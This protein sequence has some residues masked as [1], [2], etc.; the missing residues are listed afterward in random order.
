ML[1]KFKPSFSHINYKSWAKSETGTQQQNRQRTCSSKIAI[2][3]TTFNVQ[4]ILIS[5]FFFSFRWQIYGVV[6]QEKAIR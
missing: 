6:S 5:S 3:T 4:I 1:L 2:Q